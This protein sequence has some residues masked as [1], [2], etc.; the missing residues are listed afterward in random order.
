MPTT[1][2]ETRQMNLQDG[3][4]PRL[5]QITRIAGP[6]GTLGVIEASRH[7]GFDAKRLYFIHE[8]RDDHVRGLH[9]HKSLKQFLICLRGS[10]RVKLEN[11]NGSFVFDLTS[12]SS[13]IL[14]PPGCWRELES[15]SPGTIIAVLASEE[16]DETDYIRDYDMFRVWLRESGE[17]CVVP[18]VPLK[19]QHDVIGLELERILERE[20]HSGT[21]IAGSV[22]DE[23]E[24]AF[25]TYCQSEFAIGCGNGLD[26]LV[27]S[28]QAL[29][30]GPGDEVVVPANSFIASALAVTLAGA[31]PTFADVDPETHGI[32]G[33]SLSAVLTPNCR[34]VMPVHLYG[35]PVDMEEIGSVASEHGLRIVEDAAQAHGAYFRGKVCGS[36]GDAAGF[37]FYPTKNLGAIGDAGAIVT[38]DGELARRMRMLGNYGSA[39]KY[40]HELLGRNSRLDP[41]QAG[42]LLT[43][44]KHLNAWSDRRRS[45]ATLYFEGLSNH[46]HIRL[47][48]IPND[49]IPVWHVFPVRVEARRRDDCIA[50]LT[51]HGIQTNIHYP[52]P[53]HLQPAYASLGYKSGEFPVSEQAARELISLPLDAFHTEKEIERVIDVLRTF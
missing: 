32:T 18:Y 39:K 14:I 36:F 24:R 50:H 40:H 9:A 33:A 2:V 4:D 43:K 3:Q 37:S 15:F 49:R 31:H 7:M 47:P 22:L 20:L 19:R 26:A 41:I 53:I 5:V 42:V 28:F 12:P 38:N 21:Y 23:F 51:K 6:Q 1:K 8:I 46:P 10:V 13:G 16:Y 35:I 25:A 27:I 29:G 17:H 11:R 30:I 52:V 48:V 34:A 45:L 44:L